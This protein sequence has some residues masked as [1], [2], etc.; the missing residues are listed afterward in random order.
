[1]VDRTRRCGQLPLAA[2]LAIALACP[3]VT[4]AASTAGTSRVP[5]KLLGVWHKT[6]T[7]AQWEH[8][9]VARD[10]GGYTFVVK[11]PG[12]VTIYKPGDYRPGCSACAEDFT[13]TFSPTGSHLTIGNVPV[14]S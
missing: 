6:M 11:K 14:C 9:G 8:A 12:T 3:A 1:M 13:T 5:V 10:A 7:S 4:A 2:A